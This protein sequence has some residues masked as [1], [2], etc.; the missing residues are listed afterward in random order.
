[1]QGERCSKASLKTVLN[2]SLEN[3]VALVFDIYGEIVSSEVSS[4]NNQSHL[5]CLQ[6]VTFQKCF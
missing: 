6:E 3:S 1:M 4:A 2:L 5:A